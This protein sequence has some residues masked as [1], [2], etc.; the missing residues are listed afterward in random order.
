MDFRQTPNFDTNSTP[1]K[2]FIIHGTLGTYEG[3]IEWLCTP[4]EKRNPVR[5]SSAH[6]V[7]AKNGNTTQLAKHTQR[8]WHAGLISNPDQEAREVLPK[9]VLGY[10]NPND[11]FI[12]IE[13]E[14]FMGD[15]VT[16]SQI[17]SC[18]D[19]IKNSGIENPIILCHK[20]VTDHK[21]DFQTKEGAIDYTVTER[22][23][24]KLKTKVSREDIKNQIIALVKQL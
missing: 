24:E 1:N 21:A 13:L 7:I 12:G 22:I 14:W 4:P 17:N 3:A 2:G 9:G 19:I 20:Q 15:V 23:K 5:Y 16:E 11:S 18:V 8:T 10:K 6:Y